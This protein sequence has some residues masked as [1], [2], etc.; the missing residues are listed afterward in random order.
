MAS[1]DAIKMWYYFISLGTL[2]LTKL[3][4]YVIQ[5]DYKRLQ[6]TLQAVSDDEPVS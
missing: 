3:A 5:A 6:R 2:Y 1:E 4:D